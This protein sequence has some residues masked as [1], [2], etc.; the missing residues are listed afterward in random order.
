MCVVLGSSEEDSHVESFESGL[1]RGVR[2]ADPGKGQR[3]VA[4]DQKKNNNAQKK[5]KRNNKNGQRKKTRSNKRKGLKG[6]KGQ[7]Q[8]R[9]SRKNAQKSGK[10][11]KKSEKK[12]NKKK[13]ERRQKKKSGEKKRKR[14]NQQKR[15][16]GAKVRS[17]TC[18]NN[19]CVNTAVQ[20]MQMLKGK[21]A[22]FEVQ[23]KRIEKKYN[24]S[25]KKSDKQDQFKPV[26]Q[27]LSDAAGGNISAPVCSGS[28]DSAGAVQMLNLSMTLKSCADDVNAACH[29][30]NLPAPN[31]THI[32]ECKAAIVIFKNYTG[33]C[34]NLIGSD[35]C[36]CWSPTPEQ[37][38]AKAIV[39]TCSLSGSNND[40][41]KAQKGCKDAFGKCQKY[42]DDV[43]DIIF[44]CEQSADTLKLKLKALS[45]NSDKV[46]AVA[47][48]VSGIVNARFYGKFKR[49][50]D[51]T[52]ATGYISIITQIN[53][54]VSQNPYYYLIAT[55]STT[56][57]SVT[58]VPTFSPADLASLSAVNTAL[59]VSVTTLVTAVTTLETTIFGKMLEGRIQL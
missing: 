52:T 12:K 33:T 25:S 21:V 18:L 49:S 14:K 22:N 17:S 28:S 47:S 32:S 16:N 29:T 44:A 5:R 55:L 3:K 37:A 35:A 46:A 2:E 59:Q 58:S 54:F 20:A 7:K 56:I 6:K 11:K 1:A 15:M 19:T 4:K 30:T 40:M 24:Q 43:G 53:T 23:D 57:I 48:K 8:R 51:A 38:A 39:S 34:M 50:D 42:R 27:R 9:K 13:A 31:A 41:K 36:S 45:E 10:G 26:L